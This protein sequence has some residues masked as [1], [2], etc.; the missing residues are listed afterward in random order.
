MFVLN[1]RRTGS[2]RAKKGR[3]RGSQRSLP[4][5]LVA[6]IAVVKFP[7]IASPQHQL[8][9][10]PSG[11]QEAATCQL[12]K[13]GLTPAVSGRL[14]R[15]QAANPAKLR[16]FCTVQSSCML[17][18]TV[19]L[20]LLVVCESE[21]RLRAPQTTCQLRCFTNHR[22]ASF[23]LESDIRGLRSESLR[24]QPAEISYRS[25]NKTSIKK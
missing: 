16:S 2:A 1:N 18:C 24:V 10:V 21:V 23:D 20:P 14:P 4:S 3:T 17:C 9:K 15:C 11:P 19:F 13:E 5:H 22:S 7:S 25:G 12:P 6:M 8:R